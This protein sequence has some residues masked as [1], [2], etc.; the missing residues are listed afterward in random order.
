MAYL[1]IDPMD[2]PLV[3]GE[4]WW[5]VHPNDAT[6]ELKIVP[7]SPAVCKTKGIEAFDIGTAYRVA[8]VDEHSG[9]ISILKDN[10]VC[11]MPLYIFARFFDATAFVRIR[12]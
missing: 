2:Y 9:W 1:K 6:C 12:R 5:V 10:M 11:E 3:E 8:S 7:G 4:Q